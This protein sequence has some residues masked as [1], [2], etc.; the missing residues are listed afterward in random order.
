M[1]S[2]EV[3]EHLTALLFPL[4]IA[5][6]LYGM[7]RFQGWW[8]TPAQPTAGS[9]RRIRRLIVAGLVV[10]VAVLFLALAVVR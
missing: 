1:P 9:A 4:V 6:V 10:A 8:G 5:A 3:H 7:Y 2:E